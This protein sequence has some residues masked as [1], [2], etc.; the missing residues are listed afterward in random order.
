MI[1]YLFQITNSNKYGQANESIQI[2]SV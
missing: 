2:D 1:T